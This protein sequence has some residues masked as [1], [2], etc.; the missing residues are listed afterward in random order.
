MDIKDTLGAAAD[1]KEHTV[2]DSTYMKCPEE[3][4]PE[5]P[6]VDQWCQGLRLGRGNAVSG[7]KI[8]F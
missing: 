3:A 4:D 7:P 6:K 1:I 5:R 8:S 2:Y